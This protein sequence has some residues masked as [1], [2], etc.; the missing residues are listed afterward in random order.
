MN[1][2]L[3]NA[4]TFVIIDTRYKS[5]QTP[6]F[7]IADHQC[8]LYHSLLAKVCVCVGKA[9]YKSDKDIN[10]TNITLI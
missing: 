2:C 4:L 1:Q 10:Y 7:L 6:R 9:R 8:K 5:Q 3:N